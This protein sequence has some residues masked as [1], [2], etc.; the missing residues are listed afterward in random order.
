MRL[1]LDEHYSNKIAEQLR[2]RGHD[3]VAASERAD[4]SG[5][6]DPD[7]FRTAQL[8]RRAVLTENWRHFQR[9]M[10]GETHYGVIF[11]AGRHLPRYRST[12]GLCVRILDEFL[13]RHPA[14]DALRDRWVWLK[15]PT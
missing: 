3:V 8:E 11:T 15:E 6:K 7:L 1:L 14:E 10:T 9:E 12:I 2:A 13:S 4:L 5:A